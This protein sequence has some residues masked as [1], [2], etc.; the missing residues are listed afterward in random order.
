[1]VLL[2]KKLLSLK[3]VMTGITEKTFA[4]MALIVAKSGGVI[5]ALSG[6]EVTVSDVK[7]TVCMLFCLNLFCLW[8]ASHTGRKEE[9][10]LYLEKMHRIPYVLANLL[11]DENVKRFSKRLA[12]ENAQ[13]KASIVVSSLFTN[14]AGKEIALKLEENSWSAVGRA[15]DYQEV[16]ETGLPADLARVLV[17][18]DATCAPRLDEALDVM[19]LLY[20]KRIKFAAVGLERRQEERIRQLSRNRCIFLSSL[21]KNAMQPLVTLVFYYQLAFFYGQSHGIAMSVA[22]RNLAKSMTVG[23]SLFAKVASPARELSK[24]KN[25]NEGLKATV[26]P[27]EHAERRSIWE[28]EAVTKRSRQY[29]E[30]MRELAAIISSK[31]LGDEICRAMDENTTRLAHYLFDDNSDIDE[32]VFAPMDRTSEAAVKNAA[33]IWSRFLGYPVRIITP[34]A[35]LG[36][37]KN[38]ILLFTAASSPAGQKRLTKRLETA[39]SPVFRLEPEAGFCEH[40]LAP[41]NGGKFLLKNGFEHSRNDYLYAAIHLIFINAWRTAFPEKAEI[42]SEHFRRGAETVIGVLA[43]PDL[44]AAIS[45]SMAVNKKYETMFYIGPPTGIGLAWSDKFDRTGTMLC[46]QHS[47]GESA[48]GPLV[49]VDSRV[50]AKFVKLGDR[51][52]MLS[53]FGREKVGLWEKSYLAGKTMDE[54]INAPPVDPSYEE[55]T[56]FFADETWYLPEL[57][58]DY[59]TLNDNLIVMDAAWDRYL[60][61][62]IDEIS[63]FGSR[64]PRMI[65]ITQ[66][67]FLNGK[68][69]AALYR[70]PVSSTIVLP[71]TPTGPVPEMHLSFV[72]NIIGEE[73]SACFDRRTMIDEG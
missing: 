5:P 67:A 39:S 20:R 14:G 26:A 68:A 54:F 23:R 28:K 6:E 46:E 51:N 4:D 19:E 38:N 50:D 65:L 70:F 47:F 16:M 25:L 49:T 34:E 56:P 69:K 72:L 29:Y 48:H 11:E 21:K 64:Y 35:P 60:D 22:P 9:A 3:V 43:N 37:F 73:L 31:D 44:K 61:K 59:D 18:V 13:N 40:S 58:P 62:A 15:L 66:Q 2:A 36:P 30:E 55:K 45:T 57:Q 27:S 12:R 24:I 41:K 8:L 17:V 52:E 10:F 71:E 42:V 7:S 53:T 63:T 32:I 1:M 33:R